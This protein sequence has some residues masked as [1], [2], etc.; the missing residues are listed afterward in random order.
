[1]TEEVFKIAEE[2]RKYKWAPFDVRKL[3][4]EKLDSVLL[5]HDVRT[6]TAWIEF[7]EELADS[8]DSTFVKEAES[9]IAAFQE[10]RNH[11]SPQAVAAIYQ[12]IHMPN[13]ALLAHEILAAAEYAEQ[14]MTASELSDMAMHGEFEGTPSQ[15]TNQRP[16]LDTLA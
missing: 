15:Y 8:L 10:V 2:S 14:G 3:Y 11:Y 13:N 9:L 6:T 12:T 16:R 4:A 7:A 5:H 1:M